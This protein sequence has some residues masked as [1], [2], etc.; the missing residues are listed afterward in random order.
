MFPGD[1]LGPVDSTTV[2]HFRDSFDISFTVEVGE[3]VL[4]D[5]WDVTLS[6][7]VQFFTLQFSALQFFAL[8]F[9]ALQFF[10]LQFG[11]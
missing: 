6:A 10:A 7:A 1:E 8:Q 2:V 9:F 4:R 3:I 11:D 5:S